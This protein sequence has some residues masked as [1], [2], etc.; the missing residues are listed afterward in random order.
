MEVHTAVDLGLPILFVVFNNGG[1]GMCVTRQQL[2]FESRIECSR[3][4]EPS[5]AQ[6]A[7]GFG[8]PSQLWVR[9]AET[10]AELDHTL[11]CLDQWSWRGPAVLELVLRHE[12]VPPFTPFLD[13]DAP[14]GEMNDMLSHPG[15]ASRAFAA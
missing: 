5:I 11:G 9:S 14:V 1:H 3:Y 15:T 7:R 12:E 13:A 8:G 10:V 6:I 2:F 4:A